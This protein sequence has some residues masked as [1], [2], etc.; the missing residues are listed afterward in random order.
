MTTV[1][2]GSKH[3]MNGSV[4]KMTVTKFTR[5]LTVA[6]MPAVLSRAFITLRYAPEFAALSRAERMAERLIERM[7]HLAVL[8]ER[9][10]FGQNPIRFDT[11]PIDPQSSGIVVTLT[12]APLPSALIVMALR[13]VI[14]LHDYDENGL[15]ELAQ[16]LDDDIEQARAVWA[17]VIFETSVAAVEIGFEGDGPILPF[18][19]FWIAAPNAITQSERIGIEA[20]AA[21]MPDADLEDAVLLASAFGAFWPLGI[22]PDYELGDEEWF[23]AGDSLLVTEISCETA[24]L[25]LIL[26]GFLAAR[27]V[28]GRS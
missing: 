9:G 25:D 16:V 18:D 11:K 20:F 23:T 24:A 3:G 1:W 7:R 15:M 17:G 13:M 27:H 8:S 5:K 22:A 14:G 10:F 19:P 28:D 21:A 12:G 6:P 4:P 26:N 2:T